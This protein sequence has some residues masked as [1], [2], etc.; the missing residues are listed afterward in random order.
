[1]IYQV[2]FRVFA[3]IHPEAS[4]KDEPGNQKPVL[5]DSQDA[6]VRLGQLLAKWNLIGLSAA[7]LGVTSSVTLLL[8]CFG[9][10]D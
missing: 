5:R 3:S 2:C 8:F 9:A 4:S 6:F 1:M 7:T 10:G